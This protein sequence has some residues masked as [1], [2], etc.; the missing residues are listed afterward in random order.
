MKGALAGG[1]RREGDD[2]EWQ[3]WNATWWIRVEQ[4][5]LNSRQRRKISLERMMTRE[6]FWSDELVKSEGLITDGIG[7]RIRLTLQ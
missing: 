7:G 2:D 3:R 1:W 4:R 5:N 6:R